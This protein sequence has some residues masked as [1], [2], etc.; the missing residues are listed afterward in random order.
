MKINPTCLK[1]LATLI[2]SVA[3][4]TQTHA[5]I[6][7]EIVRISNNASA[8][9]SFA[10]VD[11]FVSNS[12]PILNTTSPSS[13][14]DNDGWFYLDDTIYR[15]AGGGGIYSFASEADFL[16]GTIGTA[17]ATHAGYAEDE[18]FT[19][20]F[21]GQEKIVRVTNGDNIW[22][23]DTVTDF[24]N[25]TGTDVNSQFSD[26]SNYGDDGYFALDGAICR[27]GNAN[28]DIV[29]YDSWADFTTNTS[30]SLGTFGDYA[31]DSFFVVPEPS[32]YAAI[33]GVVALGSVMIR[34]RRFA[35]S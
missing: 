19:Y 20:S 29:N 27:I 21:S 3:L 18:W 24:I 15:T 28:G 25:N 14:Y 7:G 5:F 1:T 26:K 22:I 31:N 12:N 8:L 35:R 30:T 4:C 23:Y 33:F 9:Q 32:T 2:A 34:R 13:S 16:S 6:N 17:L 10:N 11:D